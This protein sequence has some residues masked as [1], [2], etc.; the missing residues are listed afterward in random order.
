MAAQ[1]GEGIWN[2]QSKIDFFD[3]LM[4]RWRFPDWVARGPDFRVTI[5]RR[6]HK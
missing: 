1:T 4:I 5:R 3:K 6:R 2:R